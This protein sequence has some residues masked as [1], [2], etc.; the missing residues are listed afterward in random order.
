MAGEVDYLKGEEG[1]EAV[2]HH[3]LKETFT[4]TDYVVFAYI[5]PY[6][7]QD[8]LIHMVEIEKKVAQF[9]S[10]QSEQKVVFARQEICRSLED[11]PMHLMCLTS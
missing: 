5:Y 7:C 9:N 8:L 3:T 1:T 4:P 2:F 11:R 6:T 10:S